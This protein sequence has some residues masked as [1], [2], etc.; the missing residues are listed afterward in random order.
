MIGLTMRTG[1]DLR[2]VSAGLRRMDNPELKKR[3]RKELR[4]VATPFVPLV[5]SSIR[6]IPSKRPYTADGLRGRMSK[7]T[8]VEVRTVGK[9]AGVA[10]RVD[11]RK[12]PAKQ[13]ALPKGM[14]G[15]KRWRHP[16]HGNRE[17]W[18]TQSGHPYFFKVVRPAGV[19]GRRAASKVVNSIT[20][21][22][23]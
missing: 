22:I 15:T 12:M 4:A 10:I 1:D 5:R 19:A 21:D 18:V 7:A 2:R 14:E 17:V 20:R 6:S 23:R 8:R 16:V 13:K 3:F 9:D 11:G